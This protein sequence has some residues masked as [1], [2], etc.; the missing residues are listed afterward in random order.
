[1][2]IA[3]KHAKYLDDYKIHLLFS[4]GVNHVVDFANF[5][6]SSLNPMMRKF[7]YRTEFSKFEVLYGDLM[8]NDFEMCFPI[9]ALY[10]GKI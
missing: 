5:L 7:L 4:E 10:Q 1:M 9:W 2:V 6:S 3:I 8:W